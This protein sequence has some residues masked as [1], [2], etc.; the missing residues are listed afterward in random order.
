[1]SAIGFIGTGHIAAPMARFLAAKGHQVHVTARSQ[2]MSAALAADHGA[3][4]APPQEIV[5]ACDIVFA[6]LRPALAKD[7]LAPLTFRA[8][9]AVVSVMAGVA[10][11]TL[12]RLCA[13][14]TRFVQTIPLGVLEHGG[15]PLAAY[16]D[17]ALLAGLFAPENPVVKV[18]SEAALN[19]HFAICAMVPGML[20]LALTGADWLA[21]HSGDRD[22][23]GFYTAQLVSGFLASIDKRSPHAMAAERDA[24]ATPNTLSLKMVETLRASGGHDALLDGLAAV[25]DMLDLTEPET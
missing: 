16:G 10:A 20:D 14:V 11:D 4:I 7:V 24:L 19:A 1:M 25:G 8:D 2:Q 3:I 9:Q 23:A 21:R 18:T 15:C 13:P 17:D 5:D 12:A 6:C 22:A